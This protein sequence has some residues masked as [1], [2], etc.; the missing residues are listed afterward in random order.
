M[1]TA[2]A[3]TEARRL[4]EQSRLDELKDAAD[5]NR[6]GQFATPPQLSLDIARYAYRLWPRRPAKSVAFL[7]PAI[8]TGSFF[9]AL[10]HVFPEHLIDHATGVELDA[11]FA[12][13]AATLWK[14]AG[15]DVVQADFT[16]RTPQHQFNL[17]LTN[18]PYVRHHHLE[19]DAKDRLKL[20]VARDLG[21]TLSGLAGLYCYFLLLADKWLAPDGLAVWL[22][23]SEFMAVNYGTAVKDYLKN[24]VTLLHIHRFCPSDVQFSDALVSSA[25]VVF[26]KAPPPADHRVLFSFGGSLTEPNASGSVPASDLYVDDKWTKFPDTPASQVDDEDQLTLGDLFTIKR[27]VATGDNK[28]FVIPKAEADRLGIP[29]RY[30]RP[31]LPS[32]RYLQQSVVEARP[33][34]YA[35][36]PQPL[37]LIDCDLPE[38]ALQKRH[39]ELWQYL[40]QGKKRG[41]HE[42]YLASRRSPWYSQEQRPPAPFLCTYMGRTSEAK[43]GK[44]FRFLW[45]KSQ[46]TA[47]NVYL[48]LYPKPLLQHHLASD[49]RLYAQVFDTLSRI[50]SEMFLSESRVYGGGLYKLEPKE[51]A[52]VSAEP[53]LASVNG[54]KLQQQ[55]KLFP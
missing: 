19:A 52:R 41:I 1:L 34:G 45:N 43:A 16:T 46:A 2:L 17:I 3:T 20:Q 9:S 15:L 25:I 12:A 49:P 33:D 50:T 54:I 11:A 6:W 18:P 5:R 31:I 7:D 37:C 39:P 26:R 10:R 28:F 42:G 30:C 44:P 13:T 21:I 23:P 55:R 32:P 22:I 48:M 36:L 35:H 29:Q 40:Q 4:T 27:G 8:G 47:A 51:L 38:D 14:G 24:R 53:I